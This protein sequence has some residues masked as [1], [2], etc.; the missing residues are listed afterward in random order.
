MSTQAGVG[1]S[2]QTDSRA[3]GFE[4][5][6]AACAPLA[7]RAPAVCLVFATAPHAQADVLAGVREAAGEAPITG[8]SAEGIIAGAVS[9]ESER[10][11]AVLAVASDQM[12]F[13]AFLVEGYADDPAAAGHELARQVRA[14]S[15]GDESGLLLFPDGLGGN[16]TLLLAALAAALPQGMAIAGGAAGDEMAF[17]RCWQY[18]GDKVAT[19]AVAALLVRGA[20]IEVAVSHGCLPIGRERTITRAD[21]NWLHEIDGRPAWSVFKEYLDGDPQ[22]LNVEGIT[23]LCIGV[24]LPPEAAGEYEPYIIRTPMNLDRDTGSLFFSGGGLSEGTR[25]RLT[26]R[27]EP[28]IRESA[29]TCARRIA[30]RRPGPGPAFVVQF[31]CAGR[32]HL[33]FGSRVAENIVQPLQEWLGGST[34]WVGFHTYGEIAAVAGQ[35]WYHNYTVALCAVYETP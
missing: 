31:D 7:G 18:R 23:H 3:A 26:R 21:D 16:C 14:A 30:E 35:T 8:C 34:P 29:R 25:I 24:S 32:G 20:S 9:D 6:R 11:V 28:R 12:S 19:G 27:D 4:A 2:T 1:R 17:E 33:L 5:A 13:D 15:R 10:A 22:D